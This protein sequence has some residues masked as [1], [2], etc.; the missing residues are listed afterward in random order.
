[1]V[2]DSLWKAGLFPLV[3]AGVS[4]G[5]IIVITGVNRW[6]SASSPA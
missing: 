1:M 3:H 2:D 5:L 6:V 4:Q